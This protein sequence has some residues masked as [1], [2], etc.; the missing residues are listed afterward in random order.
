MEKKTGPNTEEGRAISS[1]NAVTHG[2]TSTLILIK[3]ESQDDLDAHFAQ[4]HLQYPTTNDI[5]QR[6][7]TRAALSEW[8]LL[9]LER[10]FNTA[11]S[12]LLANP[13]TDWTEADHARY[14]NIQRYLTTAQRAHHRDR[15]NLQQDRAQL[16]A[17]ELHQTRM[18]KAFDSKHEAP[19]SAPFTNLE[20]PK[21]PYDSTLYQE[22]Y[23]M[24]KNGQPS[25]VFVPPNDILLLNTD[26][27]LETRPITRFIY[28]KQ[29]PVAPGYE[30]VVDMLK[31]MPPDTIGLVYHH[32]AK[33]FR[34]IAE[35]EKDGPVQH[36]EDLHTLDKFI[37]D[38][39]LKGPQCQPRDLE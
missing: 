3:D 38:N 24:E 7:V 21:P 39:K 4:W 25:A 34:I 22:I 32:T 9:R 10:Q 11:S 33:S 26:D 14:K 6:L 35:R 29:E 5:A 30:W 1:Q 13:I 37:F 19:K 31:Q 12:L 36:W 18:A 2:M 27:S 23:L 16:R 17:E 15:L 20:T 8:H 28:V